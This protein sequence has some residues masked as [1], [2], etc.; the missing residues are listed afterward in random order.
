M[1]WELDITVPVFGMVKDNN[2]RTR[3]ITGDGG[4]IGISETKSAFLLVTRIQDEVHRFA[5]TYQRNKHRKST[6]ELGITNVKGI[7]E[8]KA[9]KLL[10]HFKTVEN[11]KK[12]TVEE[13][14]QAGGISQSVANDVYEFVQNSL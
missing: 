4:E 10:I 11:L 2:H 5:F 3:A 6:F 9:M 14:A 13:V 1:L 8:K 7:G 12:A